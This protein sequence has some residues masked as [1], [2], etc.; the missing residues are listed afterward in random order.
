M[1]YIGID[2]GGTNINAGLVDKEGKLLGEASVPTPQGAG[3]VADAI[4]T[5]AQKAAEKA[6][7]AMGEVQSLSLIHI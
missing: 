7:I 2:L 6:G 5:A 4:V 1:Y 3:A